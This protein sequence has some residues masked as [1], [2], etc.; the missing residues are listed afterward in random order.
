MQHKTKKTKKNMIRN[1]DPIAKNVDRN[2]LKTC[3][4]END[5]LNMQM[6][7]NGWNWYIMRYLFS[8]FLIFNFISS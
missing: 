1:M 2:K 4:D 8:I 3:V 5:Q 7:E 6:N